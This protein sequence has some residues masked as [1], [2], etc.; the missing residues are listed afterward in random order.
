MI[1]DA[2]C[3]SNVEPFLT[4][5]EDNFDSYVRIKFSTFYIRRL[6]VELHSDK[7][8]ERLFQERFALSGA[9]LDHFF[10]ADTRRGRLER[11]PPAGRLTTQAFIACVRQVRMA[12]YECLVCHPI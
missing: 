7:F 1:L 8:P 5:R 3:S 2:I 4:D 10:R 6:R 11:P 12:R 9:I